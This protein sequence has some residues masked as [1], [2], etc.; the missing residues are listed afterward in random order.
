[1]VNKI[2]ISSKPRAT[3]NLAVTARAKANA[4]A[5][6][7]YKG[8]L[9]KVILSGID[10]LVSEFGA[11]DDVSSKQ[12]NITLPDLISKLVDCSM[13]NYDS[14]SKKLALYRMLQVVIGILHNSINQG[15]EMTI[16]NDSCAW[17][18]DILLE[19]ACESYPDIYKL[20]QCL[21][22]GEFE[23]L[24]Q[25][26]KSLFKIHELANF[27]NN[28]MLLISH[29][30]EIGCEKYFPSVFQTRLSGS[31]SALHHYIARE[32]TACRR[33]LKQEI[34]NYKSSELSHANFNLKLQELVVQLKITPSGAAILK[35]KLIFSIKQLATQLQFDPKDYNSH[36][37]G[38]NQSELSEAELQ[39]IKSIM[40]YIISGD[41]NTLQYNLFS[42]EAKKL[43][44]ELRVGILASCKDFSKQNPAWQ[45]LSH[46]LISIKG[47][48]YVPKLNLSPQPSWRGMQTEPRFIENKVAINSIV[49]TLADSRLKDIMSRPQKPEDLGKLANGDLELE[50]LFGYLNGIVSTAARQKERVKNTKISINTFKYAQYLDE[51]RKNQEQGDDANTNVFIY[52][53]KSSN[54]HKIVAKQNT[55]AGG[56]DPTSSTTDAE[57]YIFC[58]TQNLRIATNHL[59]ANEGIVITTSASNLAT[60]RSEIEG[61][62]IINP[63]IV[64]YDDSIPKCVI[65]TCGSFYPRSSVTPEVAEACSQ[66]AAQHYLDTLQKTSNLPVVIVDLRCLAFSRVAGEMGIFKAHRKAIEGAAQ[67]IMRS[68][69]DRRQLQCISLGINVGNKYQKFALSN[70]N[71][72]QIG[73]LNRF[74]N[75]KTEGVVLSIQQ[76]YAKYLLARLCDNEGKLLEQRRNAIILVTCLMILKEI[77]PELLINLGC[78]SAKDRTMSVIVGA[79]IFYNL[80]QNSQDKSSLERLLTKDNRI[81][82]SQLT[83]Q[84][85]ALIH[86]MLIFNLP[87]LWSVNAHYNRVS[88][89]INS[90][91]LDSFLKECDFVSGV[92]KLIMTVHIHG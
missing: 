80:I 70:I 39:I 86:Q 8:R 72:S 46:F 23:K 60:Q 4:I 27:R 61:I 25:G 43:L 52:T 7:E 79:K 75:D 88:T 81:N 66:F 11:S 9:T 92:L 55:S 14:N 89:N 63:N 40:N 2:V 65:Y 28:L 32:I 41:L 67:Q 16:V 10:N 76:N 54:Q 82:N 56:L 34:N 77:I 31:A 57:G 15:R 35:D 91:V 17:D 50:K 83:A 78:K 12:N 68:Q 73:N 71:T 36:K 58:Q 69:P 20:G 30:S 64:T 87:M 3:L 29:R 18:A 48:S 24:P 37:T 85:K 90:G 6:H 19:A 21:L 22:S 33:Q 53:T 38:G 42:A 5:P 51:Q 44:S 47:A 84:Q 49:A 62:R 26:I 74:I 45:S 13:N 1:M 59:V